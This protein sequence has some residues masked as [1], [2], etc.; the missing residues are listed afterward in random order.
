M[1]LRLTARL[2]GMTALCLVLA[3]ASGQTAPSIAPGDR[4]APV[5]VRL[6]TDAAVLSGRVFAPAGDAE[7]PGVVIL[8]GSERGPQTTMKQQL[9]EHFADAGIAALIYDSPG[10]GGSTGNALLQ[11]RADRADEAIAGVKFLAGRDGVLSNRVGVMGISEGALVTMLAAARDDSIAFAIPVSGSFGVS[12]PE[13]T[14]YRIETMCLARAVEPEEIQKALLLEEILFALFG[15]PEG[16]EWRLIE[17]KTAG[18]ADEP[19]D[20]LIEL[21]RTMRYA[22]TPDERSAA[23]ESLRSSLVVFRD[24]PWFAAVVV[25]PERFDAF[26]AMDAGK[27]YMFL[28]H[29][30]L[31]DDDFGKVGQEFEACRSVACPVLAIWGEQDD[32]LPPHR[33]AA[34][35]RRCFDNGGNDDVTL[36]I[37]PLASHILTEPGSVDRFAA[38]YPEMLSTWILERFATP[39]DR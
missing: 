8:G 28:R 3:T 9:A 7:V 23:L 18:W 5:P 20:K 22:D 21:A 19:W 2:A 29:S 17:A 33:S 34:F 15:N 32:Y 38:G 16:F 14:R 25:D 13:V 26:M 10:T 4:P 36:V 31:G 24:R 30:P 37:V 12:T 11:T 1:A 35:L 39:A 6:E 27:F